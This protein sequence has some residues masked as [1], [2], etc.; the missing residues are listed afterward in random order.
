MKKRKAKRVKHLNGVDIESEIANTMNECEKIKEKAF[1]NL[2]V[3]IIVKATLDEL[4]GIDK[5]PG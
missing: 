3:N 4:Y 2:I 5:S 1:L